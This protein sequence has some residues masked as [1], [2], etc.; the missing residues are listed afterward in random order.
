MREG[1][2]GR[3]RRLGEPG[4]RVVRGSRAHGP[5]AQRGRIPAAAA[6]KVGD[7]LSKPISDPYA[8]G[9]FRV[10]LA[11]VLARRALA[12][13]GVARLIGTSDHRRAL[14]QALRERSYRRRPRA[15]DV[16]LLSR[17]S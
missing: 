8:S 3:G 14:H 5:G 10:H 2:P 15:G 16:A 9:E 13:R 12:G 17:S 11:T 4:A 7:G 1:Q 6:A